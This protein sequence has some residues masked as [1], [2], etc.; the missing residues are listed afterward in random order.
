VTPIQDAA[1]AVREFARQQIASYDALPKDDS[2][3]LQFDCFRYFLTLCRDQAGLRDE[4][5]AG[6]AAVIAESPDVFQASRVAMASGI[7]V[8]W[9][10]DPSIAIAAMLERLPAQ[11]ASAATVVAQINAGNEAALFAKSPDAVKAWRG[12]RYMVMP[13]M[14]MLCLNIE[15]RLL[16]RRNAN[17]LGQLDLLAPHHR[18]VM[19]LH[20]LLNLADGEE[21]III[22]PPE[23]KGFRV[24]LEAVASSFHLFSL[25][26][27]VLV[28]DPAKGMLA[29]PR[30]NRK[31]IATATGEIPHDRLITDSAIWHYYNWTGLQ[32]DG[33]LAAMPMTTWVMGEAMPGEIPLFG[34]ERVVLLGPPVLASRG[35]D[36]SF[37]TNLH[38]A[39]RSQVEVVEMLSLDEVELRLKRIRNAPRGSG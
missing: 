34:G 22:H 27:G 21:L 33:T 6:L 17:L 39:L 9:G 12:L 31:V 2:Q 24:R 20:R 1:A 18:E 36:S 11:L 8:E 35:W 5:L 10:A 4:A 15:L 14:T 32:P 16:A 25:L 37:F 38:D 19:F 23:N 29:G 3:L 7:I 13:A 30:P 28:G 26:Q